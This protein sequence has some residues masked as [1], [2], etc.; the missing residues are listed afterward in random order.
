M[1]VTKGVKHFGHCQAC[2]A[3]WRG[4]DRLTLSY[5]D[6]V[7]LCGLALSQSH[8]GN[9]VPCRQGLECSSNLAFLDRNTLHYSCRVTYCH[10]L[11]SV[12]ALRQNL[13]VIGNQAFLIRPLIDC[14]RRPPS[15][16]LERWRHFVARRTCGERSPCAHGRAVPSCDEP[17][18]EPEHNDWSAVTKVMHVWGDFDKISH[19]LVWHVCIAWKV[20]CC[21][22]SYSDWSS[23]TKFRC[24]ASPFPA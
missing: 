16:R 12:L 13:Q 4:T 6:L 18:V 1:Q 3:L 5:K 9:L 23:M 20:N 10:L 21:H 15:D 24:K 7:P 19:F 22:T 2:S 11:L 14:S 8:V 17:R